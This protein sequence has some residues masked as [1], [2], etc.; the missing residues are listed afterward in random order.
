MKWIFSSHSLTSW[1]FPAVCYWELFCYCSDR[2]VPC[3]QVISVS[4]KADSSFSFFVLKSYICT[5]SVSSLL[6]VFKLHCVSE[7]PE[8]LVKIQ[9][10]GPQSWSF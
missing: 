10:T 6:L 7:S 2:D 3:Q 9:I 1:Q 5:L 4:I 8:G